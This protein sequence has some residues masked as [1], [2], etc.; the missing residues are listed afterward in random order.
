V[1]AHPLVNTMTTTIAMADLLKIFD[2]S[3][4]PPRWYALPL[5]QTGSS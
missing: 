3:G 1:S 2:H 5:K 4:H